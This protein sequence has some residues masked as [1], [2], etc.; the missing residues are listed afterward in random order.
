[1]DALDGSNEHMARDFYEPL[2][3]AH[4]NDML[5]VSKAPIDFG[6]GAYDALRGSLGPWRGMI[7]TPWCVK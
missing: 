1:M 2:S 3:T 6:D 7:S 5:G 4:T